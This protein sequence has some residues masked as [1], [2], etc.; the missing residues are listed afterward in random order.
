MRRRNRSWLT[1]ARVVVSILTVVFAGSRCAPASTIVLK[2]GRQLQGKIGKTPGLAINPLSPKAEGPPTITFV[3]D[4]LR[5]VFVPTFRIAKLLEADTG[6]IKE[7]INISQRV[8]KTGNRVLRVGPITGITPFDERGRRT[9][10]MATDKGPLKVIQGI[11]QI[12]P[13]WTKVEGLATSDRTPLMWDMRIAT[14]SIPFKTLD[15]I[16]TQAIDPKSLDQRLKVVRLLLQAERYKDAQ[17]KLE[18]VIADFP[19]QKDLGDE[20][21]AMRQLYARSVV[22]EAEVRRKAGQTDL[23]FS[24][25]DKFP[26]DDIAGEILQQVREHVDGYQAERKQVEKVVTTLAEKIAK[27]TDP[28]RQQ[29]CEAML[30]E[31]KRELSLN[32][33]DRMADY[34]RLLDDDSMSPDQHVSLAISGWLLGADRAQP[35]LAVTMSLVEVREAVRRYLVEPVKLERTAIYDR[36]RV[37]EG[38]SPALVA[39]LIARMKPPMPQPEDSPGKPGF[40]QFSLPVGIPDEPDVTYYVQLPP[41]YDPYVRY[42][43]ILTLNGTGT[44]PEQQIDWWAGA[45][46]PDGMRLGQATR[47]GYIVVAVDWLKEGQHDYGFSAREHSAVLASLRD[48]ARRFSIDTDRVFLTGHSVGGNAVWDIGL[49]HPDLWAGVMPIVGLAEK[50]C[51]LYWENAALVPFYVVGG[52]MD[53]DKTIKNARDLDRYL[54]KRYDVT[55]TEYIGRGHEDFY[56]D[57]QNLFDWMERKQ[58]DFF[59]KQFTVS[60]MR[61][62]D[63][64]FWWFEGR[65]FPPKAMVD[66]ASWPP[67]RGVRPVTV[68]GKVTAD[69]GLSISSGDVKPTIWLSPEQVDFNRRVPI[70]VNG[71]RLKTGGL[72]IEPDLGVILEDVRTRGDRQHPFWARIDP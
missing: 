23:A 31:I 56:E 21:R 72:V 54:T 7:R 60:T 19:N 2:D 14:S 39:Q 5:R 3:D 71:K 25:L 15:A 58:R 69:N 33:L 40:H 36:L 43:T 46:G 10:T 52:E 64:Y 47:R 68:T 65:D 55:V 61:T 18:G 9:L 62:W 1:S 37:M 8:A 11:T 27:L 44:T 13:V 35:N 51:S 70:T 59:P 26:S 29:Q 42:P 12:T 20:V 34:L 38:S 67:T 41:Q 22:S 30:E 16:L 28:K 6:E 57:I 63:N 45:P 4:D 49:A 50:Y 24:M 53:G 32:T 17:Q 66:P 48:A